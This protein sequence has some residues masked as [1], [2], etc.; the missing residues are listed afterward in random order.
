MAA[1]PL[2]SDELAHFL[3]SGLAIMAATRDAELQPDGAWAWAARV[4]E[5]RRHLTVYFQSKH[6]PALLKNLEAHPEIA[7]AFDLPSS[8]R[9]C[10]VKGQV[11]KTRRAR[12][13]ERA[14]VERQAQAFLADLALIGIPQAMTAGWQ[15]WPSLAVELRVTQLFEQTPG[16]GTGEPMP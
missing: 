4:H 15:Y 8:H 7:L 2:L 10:Q 13:G 11:V 1:S 9:A 6:G 16:P 5:D 14:E 3:Q 12:P